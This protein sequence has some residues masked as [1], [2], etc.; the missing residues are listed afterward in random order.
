MK[1]KKVLYVSN[2][3]VPY[4]A[5]FFNQLSK[6]IDLTVLYERKRSSNRDEK[7]VNSVKSN[8]KIEYL[9]GIKIKNEYSID[10]RILKHVFNKEYDKVIIGCYN[11]P[12]QILAMLIMRLFKKK[13]ILNLDGEYSFEGN[14]LKQKAK[15]FFIKGAQDYLIAGEKS[16]INLSKLI[17]AE[18]VHTYYFSSLTDKDLEKNAKNNNKNINNKILVVGQYFDYKGLDIVLKV[19]K[20]IP[21][22]IFKFV[23]MGNRSE[24]F[25]KDVIEIGAKNIEIVPFLTKEKLEYEYKS[26]KMLVLPS[27][28]ECWGLVI[29]EAASYGMP[30][31]ASRGAGA[32]IEFLSDNYSEFLFIPEDTQDLEDKIKLLDNYDKIN[33]YSIYLISK[34]KKYSVERCVNEYL[35][36]INKEIKYE[37]N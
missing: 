22:R 5:E 27:R 37:E 4:R 26:C 35:K 20:N 19:A 25:K 30:I 13:Y 29:N 31:V 17:P 10:L 15:R 32:A 24:L 34:S 12:S 33:L 16:A 8:Y 11:S 1:K 36:V 21:D 28:N 18:K 6:K 23:G 14:G 2:I 9:K 7:W 3:E